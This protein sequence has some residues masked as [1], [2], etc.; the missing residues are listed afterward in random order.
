M[1]HRLACKP[2]IL[3]TVTLLPAGGADLGRE[4]FEYIARHCIYDEKRF[5]S[6]P[7]RRR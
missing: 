2:E 1:L 5:A 6:N 7:I 3:N 4:T